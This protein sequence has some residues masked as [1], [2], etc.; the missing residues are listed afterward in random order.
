MRILYTESSSNLG[1]QEIQAVT[2]MVALKQAGH[3]VILACRR[4]SRIS[5]IASRASIRV[6]HIPFRNSLHLT[7]VRMLRRLIRSF[8]PE[9]LIC[10]S[11]H[12][13]NIAGLTRAFLPGRLSGFSLIRQKTYLTR[14][15][16]TFSLNHLCDVVVVPGPVMRD[17]LVKGGCRSPVVVVPPGFDF[18]ALRR[19]KRMP[20]AEHIR[21]WL[22]CRDDVPV[23]VQ[24]GM[25]RHEKGQDFMLQTLYRLRL[26][27]Q[28]FLWL[29]VGSG[30]L[31]DEYRLRSDILSLGMEDCVMMCGELA[32]VAP[33]W[34]IASLMVMPSRN[35]AFGMVAVEAAACGVPVMVSDTGGLPAVIQHGR[36]GTL[37]QPD[38]QEAWLA[39]LHDFF[40]TPGR[41]LE[42]ARQATEDMEARYGIDGTV[43]KL[44]ALGKLYGRAR[45]N[46][47]EPG[48]WG[49]E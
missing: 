4:R 35:E 18:D 21:L 47:G 49:D 15:T 9:L 8:R 26:E 33:V 46:T 29:I 10:H 11:G 41:F 40:S 37:L 1:G 23:I 12:D 20:L 13:S 39:A 22:K 25:L 3:K 2:Q 31:E 44:L 45:R 16:K 17:V 48:G 42:M 43:G 14:N 6:I 24:A 19:E 38:D 36:N 7:S 30:R 32:P 5:S 27:G 34:R 28:R